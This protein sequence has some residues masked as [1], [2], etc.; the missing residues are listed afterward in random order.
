MKKG[1]IIFIGILVVYLGIMY[2][3]IGKNKVNEKKANE[4]LVIRNNTKFYYNNYK[5][6]KINNN[7]Y[8]N[9]NGKIYNVYQNQS[10]FGNYEL[11][12]NNKWYIFDENNDSIDYDD[13]VFAYSG[14]KELKFINFESLNLD[15]KDINY[16][17]KALEKVE[18]ENYK[19]YFEGKKIKINYDNDS[20]DELVYIVN[21][22][23]ESRVFTLCFLV[24]NKD[25]FIID[26]DILNKDDSILLKIY[27]FHSIIDIGNDKKYEIIISQD[28]YSEHIPHCHYMLYNNREYD[29][30]TSCELR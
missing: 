16:I 27:N 30:V 23:Y 24:D 11:M 14:K 7:D 21:G 25:V 13:E 28:T 15:S 2:L 17:N 4:I 12:F 22:S 20:K 29:V 9:F 8:L 1:I 5:W 6:T 18:I 3:F 19:G 10:F 26:S